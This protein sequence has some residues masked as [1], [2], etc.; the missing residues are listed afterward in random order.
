[1]VNQAV[2]NDISSQ[3]E[4]IANKKSAINLKMTAYGQW[5]DFFKNDNLAAIKMKGIAFE[6]AAL[7][8]KEQ[9]TKVDSER[10]GFQI[11][12]ARLLLEKKSLESQNEI[13]QAIF[14]NFSK[15]A[16]D[17]QAREKTAKDQVSA[18]NTDMIRA[19]SV[20]A[21][22]KATKAK[23]N[24][25][26]PQF[27]KIHQTAKEILASGKLDQIEEIWIKHG[28]NG[29]FNAAMKWLER[30]ETETNIGKVLT[31]IDEQFAGSLGAGVLKPLQ[32]LARLRATMASQLSK[33]AG[34]VGND[35][36]REQLNAMLSIP[37]TVDYEQGIGLV[38]QLRASVTLFADLKFYQLPGL[39]TGPGTRDKG[40]PGLT[41]ILNQIPDELPEL[42]KE[43][44]I[45]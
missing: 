3:R 10:V 18:I 32:K 9:E 33:M 4:A 28:K 17:E 5:K 14:N 44:M 20:Q 41:A 34:N 39:G 36:Q 7:A 16:S 27:L 2:Q 31:M 15:G 13:Q 29:K 24:K 12:N 6:K 35:N 26:P 23:E 11:K 21:A 25:V 8:L 43:T 30:I 45:Q 19:F 38:R 42:G 40:A 22:E 37:L 1:M